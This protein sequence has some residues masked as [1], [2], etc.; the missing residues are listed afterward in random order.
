MT[1]ASLSQSPY[2]TIL[3]DNG[4][5][6]AG[7]LVYTYSAGT[8][9]PKA[10][11]VDY[12]SGIYNTN[13]VVCDSA[14]R[15]ELWLDAGLYKL[16][17]TDGIDNIIK[18]V[19]GVGT[20]G[21]GTLVVNTTI[22][23]T[24]SIRA[25][26]AASA[27]TVTSLGYRTVSDNAGGTYRWVAAATG[28]DNGIVI[29]GNTTYGS[30]GRWVRLYQGDIDPRWYGAYGNGTDSDS[31]YVTLAVTYAKTQGKGL[32]LTKGTY[33]L[34]TAV[35]LSLPITYDPSAMFSFNNF[36][37]DTTAVII[38][39]DISQH[40]S[41]SNHYFPVLPPGSVVDPHWF[42]AKGDGS[43]HDQDGVNRAI[44]SVSSK[45]GTVN[46]NDG[47]YVIQQQIFSQPNVLIQGNGI[48]QISSA[49]G[50]SGAFLGIEE[51]TDL[52]DNF[53]V[54][55]LTIRGDGKQTY[56]ALQIAGSNNKVEGCKFENWNS[57]AITVGSSESPSQ[58]ENV[59]VINN[60]LSDTSGISIAAGK[61]VVINDNVLTATATTS[62]IVVYPAAIGGIEN[63]QVDRNN[64]TNCNI[65]VTSTDSTR[66]VDGLQITQN[67][68][69][70]VEV[71]QG[72][73]MSG[74]YS[75]KGRVV[76]NN[77]NVDLTHTLST[78]IFVQTTG[79]DLAV[80]YTVNNNNIQETDSQYGIYTYG[81]TKPLMVDGNAM[82]M[83]DGT[84]IKEYGVTDPSYG[85]NLVMGTPGDVYDVSAPRYCTLGTNLRSQIDGDTT[86]DGNFSISGSILNTTYTALF[87]TML[88]GLDSTN[89]GATST[90]IKINPGT[91]TSVNG[92]LMT[93]SSSITKD[94]T[95]TW[96]NGDASG[97]LG[98]GLTLT[99]GTSYHVF[100]LGKSTNPLACEAG[101]DTNVNATNLLVAS[102]SAGYDQ[103]RRLGSVFYIDYTYKMAPFFQKGDYFNF[104]NSSFSDSTYFFSNGLVYKK[105]LT[106]MPTGLEVRARVG[107]YGNTA[108]NATPLGSWM[109]GDGAA[110]ALSIFTG[111]VSN[112]TSSSWY[113]ER[114]ECNVWTDT[115]GRINIG[116]TS[117]ASTYLFFY[118]LGWMDPRGKY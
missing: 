9:T 1:T 103:Y 85:T 101:F 79:T 40:F 2:L 43:S 49:A 16:V 107:V 37:P 32:K 106:H 13:P 48:L 12:N 19:D 31:A 109:V 27:T 96:V 36:S 54:K 81:L 29:D 53:G 38:P 14:G 20:G 66:V 3:D 114:V 33:L 102:A 4:V 23:T 77:N 8:S 47:T 71:Q 82:T 94:A 74:S 75:P 62:G 112:W 30:A 86:C 5:P 92:Y 34:S 42:G 55:Y 7:A 80:S 97:G 76:I 111:S 78:G 51:S 105:T 57:T 72:I 67:T 17:I 15:A 6:V 98:S 108:I 113:P 93:L 90:S 68:V 69:S 117:T 46:I 18:V 26:S 61:D 83:V 84:A 45:G 50:M 58:F 35:D 25:L 63:L 100:A 115:S 91:C 118:E 99:N 116:T 41:V 39:G 44:L 59:S 56:P 52:V 104:L 65:T 22:G 73:Y 64:L 28:G 60:Y 95:S 21:A 11:F 110:G 88:V 89:A 87:K 70:G 10:T 24:D